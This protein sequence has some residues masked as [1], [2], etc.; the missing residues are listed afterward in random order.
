MKINR[1]LDEAHKI[2]FM[3]AITGFT[4]FITFGIIGIL[5]GNPVDLAFKKIDDMID[6]ENQTVYKKLGLQLISPTKFGMLQVFYS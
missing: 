6:E 1:L 4:N 2:T 3:R 5:A